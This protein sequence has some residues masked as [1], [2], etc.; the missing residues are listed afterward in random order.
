MDVE[1]VTPDATV[2]LVVLGTGGVDDAEME[3]DAEVYA[4]G[5]DF[6]RPGCISDVGWGRLSVVVLCCGD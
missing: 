3:G 2:A 5:F 1:A 6:P 4:R